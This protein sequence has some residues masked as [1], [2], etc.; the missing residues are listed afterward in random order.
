MFNKGNVIRGEEDARSMKLRRESIRRTLATYAIL[1]LLY[2]NHAWC[3]PASIFE[4]FSSKIESKYFV[5]HSDLPRQD[6]QRHVEFSNLFLDVVDRDFVKL[7][8]L[9]RIDAVVL[10]DRS[11]MQRFLAQRLR[12]NEPPLYGIYIAEHHLFVTYDDSG[13]GTFTHEIMHPVV[14]TELPHAPSWAWEGI[15][16]F[17]EKFYGYKEGNR[18]YLKW[19]YQNPWRIR[20]LGERLPTVSLP[21]IINRSRDQS[22]QRLVSIFLYRHGKWKTFLDLINGGEKRGY[23]TYIEAAFGQRLSDLEP[24]WRSYLQDTYARRNQLYRLP[25]SRYFSSKQEFL[26]FERQIGLP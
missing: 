11:S 16:T 3:A 23:A 8:K 15:P 19:G 22:E 20:V 26:E 18:L 12:R 1:M 17:F 5:F 9:K 10:P 25:T 21:D 6:V 2:A 24:Q 13:L 4:G 7:R 14:G